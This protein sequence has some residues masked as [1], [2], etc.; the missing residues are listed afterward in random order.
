MTQLSVPDSPEQP[1]AKRGGTSG[2]FWI[3]PEKIKL[4]CSYD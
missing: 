3:E 2:G 1:A 4:V